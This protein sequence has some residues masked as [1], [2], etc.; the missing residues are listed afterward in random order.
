[1]EC[2]GEKILEEAQEVIDAAQEGTSDAARGHVI[3]EAA[4]LIYHLFVLLAHQ[5]V[6]LGRKGGSKSVRTS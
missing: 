4:D 2:I 6:G 3:H 5:N 1:V